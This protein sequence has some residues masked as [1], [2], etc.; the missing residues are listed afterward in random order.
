MW[1]GSQPRTL[2]RRTVI[3]GAASAF[4]V[5]AAP[6]MAAELRFFARTRLS[7]GLELYTLGP[8]L[9][10]H[11]GEQ[12]AALHAIGFRVVEPSSLFGRTPRQFRALLD[13]A[14]LSAPS[15]HLPAS[16]SGSNP[17]IGEEIG[18]LA[19]AMHV[20]GI[21]TVILPFLLIPH[22]LD[23]RPRLGETY[24][25]AVARV[26]SQMSGDDWELTADFLNRRGAVLQQAG[27][28]LG[29]HNHNV[30]FFPMGGRTGLDILLENTDPKLVSFEMDAG[31]VVAAGADPARLLER[32]PG[33]FRLMHVKDIKANTKR[34]Y[35]MH[36]DP[37][38]IGGG[39]IDWAKL[40]PLAYK[41]GVRHFIIEREPPFSQP[42]IEAAR[43]DF[44]YLQALKA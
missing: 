17:A 22:R 38:K 28:S 15:M 36:M 21:E 4:L 6:V 43:L 14:G 25:D 13:K 27:L 37:A 8:D 29:Y 33:R 16:A 20:L 34:N 19:E 12:L 3:A 18:P 44:E 9:G 31:W 24:G 30:E 7:I 11:L 35:A 41:S 39:I 42:R 5:E 1:D 2:P 40:L 10:A 32:C 23:A 26:V